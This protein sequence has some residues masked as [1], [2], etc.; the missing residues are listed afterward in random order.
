MKVETF[1]ELQKRI[2]ERIIEKAVKGM[3]PKGSLGRELFTHLKVYKGDA[4]RPLRSPP[5]LVEGGGGSESGDDS[6][7]RTWLSVANGMAQASLRLVWFGVSVPL[8][9]LFFKKIIIMCR[10]MEMR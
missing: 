8:C 5:A 7:R 10:F 9:L 3:L 1:E 2:P 6:R 4:R